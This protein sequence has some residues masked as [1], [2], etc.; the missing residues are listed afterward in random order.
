MKHYF[1]NNPVPANPP[2]NYLDNLFQ[3]MRSHFVPRGRTYQLQKE[4]QSI[5]QEPTE[6]VRELFDRLA[7]M[8]DE[9]QVLT[10]NPEHESRKIAAF[11]EA[12]NPEIRAR[13]DLEANRT[14]VQV[15]EKAESVEYRVRNTTARKNVYQIDP[16]DDW[17]YEGE[18]VFNIQPSKYART[19]PASYPYPTYQVPNDGINAVQAMDSLKQTMLET[20]KDANRRLES[21]EA[22]LKKMQQNNTVHNNNNNQSNNYNNHYPNKKRGFPS[23]S[24]FKPKGR[25]YICNEFG[26]KC[27]NCPQ[28]THNV[29]YVNQLPGN[30]IQIPP[31]LLQLLS[32]SGIPMQ[33]PMNS[34]WTL[35]PSSTIAPN[36][37]QPLNS[38]GMHK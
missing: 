14:L 31:Q 25:C 26:H 27:A 10:R 3:V 5:H 34:N 6:T 18:D 38:N 37:S 9:L 1:F 7:V 23:P 11:Y 24:G 15:L 8:F 33:P 28:R 2:A 32:G 19:G 13:M 35:V 21:M 20:Q 12:L 29:H 17:Y 4:I 30:Q 22:E 36:G 16:Q